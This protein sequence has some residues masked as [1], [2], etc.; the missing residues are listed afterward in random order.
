MTHIEID[1]TQPGPQT[2]QV[3]EVGEYVLFRDPERFLTGQPDH[4]VV[5]VVWDT[6]SH[7][8]GRVPIRVLPSRVE[9]TVDPR[10]LRLIPADAIMRDIDT[11]PLAGDVRDLCP[12]AVAWLE[13]QAEQS[14][15]S[16]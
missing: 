14:G 6:F 7:G 9:R 13:Q 4:T 2:P 11:A 12:A 1:L 10:F 3:F 15:G 8:P 16:S 5:A